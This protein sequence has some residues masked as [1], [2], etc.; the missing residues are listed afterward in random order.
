MTGLEVARGFIDAVRERDADARG[1]ALHGG[2]RVLLPAAEARCAA[3]QGV[4]QMIRMAPQ[5]LQSL[6]DERAPTA[7]CASH[8][9]RAP[10]VFANYTTWPSDRRRQSRPSLLRAP[11]RDY[12][13][14]R[15]AGRA[16]VPSCSRQLL[17][18]L[19]VAHRP[20]VYRV[21]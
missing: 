8:A 5:F 16:S 14:V 10:A 19:D 18:P 1:R 4:R 2:G 6:R 12:D 15:T 13:P 17:S 11:R 7:R 20:I 21:R 9:T 3:K